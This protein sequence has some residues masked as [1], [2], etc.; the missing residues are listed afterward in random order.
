MERRSGCRGA[1]EHGCRVVSV[2]ME[3]AQGE[4]TMECCSACDQRWWGQDGVEISREG[5]L[6]ELATT[7]RR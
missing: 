6:V 4:I 7:P 5:A 1:N 3:T 2:Q